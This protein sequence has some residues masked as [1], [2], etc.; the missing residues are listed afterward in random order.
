[1]IAQPLP[2]A[3]AA[4]IAWALTQRP[5]IDLSTLRRMA[6]RDPSSVRDF[7]YQDTAT[8]EAALAEFDALP[9]NT[10]NRTKIAALLA[11]TLGQST[12]GTLDHENFER[13]AELA[14]IASADPDAPDEWRLYFALL[15]GSVLMAQT[16]NGTAFPN[17]RAVATEF[18][19][20]RPLLDSVP[21]G[22]RSEAGNAIDAV[23]SMFT[24]IAVHSEN[25]LSSAAENAERLGC[26]RDRADPD[27]QNRIRFDTIAQLRQ[28]SNAFHVHDYSRAQ[29][30][31]QRLRSL[32]E[33][34]SDSDPL[35]RHIEAQLPNL[36]LYVDLAAA[37]DE[38]P[39]A[40]VPE[41]RQRE[42][43]RLGRDR[44]L[45]GG[46][47]ATHLL[48]LAK[49][50]MRAMTPASMD[51]AV[52][53]ADE[54]L[55][56]IPT[57]DGERARHLATAGIVRIARW[58]TFGDPQDRGGLRV[59]IDLLAQA[60]EHAVENG[61]YA[62]LTGLARP[63][64]QAYHLDERFD[65]AREAAVTGLRGRVWTTLL[66]TRTAEAHSVAQDAADDAYFATS[67]LLAQDEPELAFWTLEMGRGLIIHAATQHRDA[68]TGLE[69]RGL[70]ALAQE[71]RAAIAE[72]AVDQIPSSLRRRVTS[73]LTGVELTSD[74]SLAENF[75]AA[76]RTVPDPPSADEVRAA[77][78]ALDYD[79]LAY[80][81]P[82]TDGGGGVAAIVPADDHARWIRMPDLTSRRLVGFG[83]MS[84]SGVRDADPAADAGPGADTLEEICDWAWGA[85]IA[86]LLEAVDFP[87]DRP[88]RIV[89]I[90]TRE[91][92]RVPWHAARHVVGGKP[93]FAVEEVVF[94]YAPSGRAF[95]AAAWSRDIPIGG[96]GLIVSDPDTAG[97]GSSLMGARVEA[98]AIRTIFY[99]EASF[100][101][102][103]ADG[104]RA[105]GGRGEPDE[106]RAWFQDPRA[107]TMLHLACHATVRA[108]RGDQPT[109]F[110]LLADGQRLSAE[111][112]VDTLS[113]SESRGLSL[114]VLAAC[115]T[116]ESGRG[117]DEAFSL[118]TALLTRGTRSVISTG[119]SVSDV[120]TSVLMFM[121][122]HFLR[123]RAL[124]P[125]DALRA[126]QLWMIRGEPLPETAPEILRA[127]S[128][129]V[130]SSGVAVWS[131]FVHFGR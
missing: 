110:L 27:S 26:M 29:E 62:I 38:D 43:E 37:D 99:P 53:L 30:L 70:H 93:R 13:A 79:A 60:W 122:H 17:P 71:W 59:G 40:N 102:R 41:E 61:Q 107:G 56:Q 47:R 87:S 92:A 75:A 31:E 20:Y 121:F 65:L 88:P 6:D 100:L 131:A 64:S 111:E 73:A 125:V 124:R 114:A 77:L 90:P 52:R 72:N 28:L 46:Q 86:P 66:Q 85:G 9:V 104:S 113:A 22:A 33:Q 18:E 95:C 21:L 68:A 11:Y 103:E 4:V 98:D 78:K 5:R 51:E 119:W 109:A 94:S 108:G 105:P 128:P 10:P 116:G 32:L 118:A 112:L 2:P 123:D 55:P 14:E 82:G 44:T 19:G 91:L 36:N 89:L 54:A 45:S 57:H 8:L 101:G 129:G 39:W 7:A 69:Q 74:G 115:S 127:A 12:M 81:V 96:T 76:M 16:A 48:A 1:M 25:D 84:Q 97:H 63:L 49:I 23:I 120:G 130:L 67:I 106:L 42:I 34:L 126:A 83:L 50:R 24:S 15:R 35:R 80:L 117:Y 3:L 58:Q